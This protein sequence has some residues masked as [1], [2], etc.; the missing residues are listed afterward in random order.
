MATPEVKQ[1]APFAKQE[2]KGKRVWCSCGMSGK[3]PY[4]DGS[5]A[6]TGQRPVMVEILEEKT[7]YWCGC[8]QTKTP[9][10]CDG[11]HNST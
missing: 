3:D 1:K 10:Y 4:C 11:S 6:G 8:K 5:H 2:T 7:V 9:P